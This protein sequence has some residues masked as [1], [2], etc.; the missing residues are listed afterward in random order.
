MFPFAKIADAGISVL[1]TYLY[2]KAKKRDNDSLFFTELERTINDVIAEVCIM[3]K[4]EVSSTTCENIYNTVCK[5]IDSKEFDLYSILLSNIEGLQASQAKEI[6]SRFINKF[7]YSKDI[8]KFCNE[9]G[10]F[11]V[12][13]CRENLLC[14]MGAQIE[15]LEIFGEY[16]REQYEEINSGISKSWETEVVELLNKVLYL[17]SAEDSIQKMKTIMGDI[18]SCERKV[19][20]LKKYIGS[21]EENLNDYYMK[22]ISRLKDFLKKPRFDRVYSI[23]GSNGSGKST[24]IDG[25]IQFCCSKN[26]KDLIAIKISNFDDVYDMLSSFFGTTI[27]SVKDLAF[28]INLL[29]I[30]LV[31]VIDDMQNLI[32]NVGWDRIAFFIKNYSAIVNVYWL[33]AINTD[34]ISGVLSDSIFIEKYF[35]T[36]RVK[37]NRTAFFNFGYD[38][39]EL[40]DKTHIV[41][42]IIKNGCIR[43]YNDLV[44]AR[45]IENTD[46]RTP[47]E[48]KCLLLCLNSNENND[49]VLDSFSGYMIQVMT[50]VSKRLCDNGTDALA[51][52]GI[53]E[54]LK[55]KKQIFIFSKDITDKDVEQLL[56][57]GLIKY[58]KNE[59]F[60]GSYLGEVKALDCF[61]YWSIILLQQLQQNNVIKSEQIL[62]YPDKLKKY[63]MPYY[64]YHMI[65]GDKEYR[66]NEL[67]KLDENEFREMLFSTQRCDKDFFEVAKSRI[68]ENFDVNN[69]ENVIAVLYFVFHSKLKAI[70]KMQ[71]LIHISDSIAEHNYYIIF[72]HVLASILENV[73]TLDSIKKLLTEATQIAD[74]RLSVISGYTLGNA[75]MNFLGEEFEIEIFY[76]M[77]YEFMHSKANI[78]INGDNT[79]SFFMRCCFERYIEENIDNLVALYD[80]INQKIVD[81]INKIN[82]SKHRKEKDRAKISLY[83]NRVIRNNI[84]NAAGNFYCKHSEKNYKSLYLKQI[85]TY[86]NGT[87]EL[88][89]TAFYLIENSRENDEMPFDKEMIPHLKALSRD[90]HIRNEVE[91]LYGNVPE[92]DNV[93]PKHII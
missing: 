49:S 84:T 3:F 74:R 92:W 50:V 15:G 21:I 91:R 66:K 61:P 89:M 12:S 51:L 68:E 57:V 47:A 11:D 34:R 73:S 48:A 53:I 63:M 76:N 77:I 28:F 79:Y 59:R 10:D 43:H 27:S 41:N 29:D 56:D 71:L 72:E 25:F 13:K 58:A 17:H 22:D 18:V 19:E 93:I 37:R 90:R 7:A 16:Y 38:I 46:V 85:L 65:N 33:T 55:D 44:V 14:E 60:S 87:S 30:K 88:M 40:N 8:Q 35:Y 32:K 67:E 52:Y 45:L 80:F 78:N 62:L 2:E 54:Y 39:D 83:I 24:F 81:L 26:E 23:V 75:Y 1:L 5:G 31:F 6:C 70:H 20:T 4:L 69:G 42:Q 82:K 9:N 36:Y 64:F 86:R